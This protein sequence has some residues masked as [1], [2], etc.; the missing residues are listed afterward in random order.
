MTLETGCPGFN[1]W[2]ILFLY[3]LFSY[4]CKRQKEARHLFLVSGILITVARDFSDFVHIPMLYQLISMVCGLEGPGVGFT[5]I[6]CMQVMQQ[7]I[8]KHK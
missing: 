6:T 3:F 2:K 7:L 8:C 5:V 1:S 4:I